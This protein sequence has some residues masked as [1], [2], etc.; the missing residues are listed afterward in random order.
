L[1]ERFG[2]ATGVPVVLNTSFNLKGQPIVDTPAQAFETFS[3]CEMDN[4]VIERFLV[5]K[6]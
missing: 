4:L 5:E 6:T 3:K 1:I 2:Q